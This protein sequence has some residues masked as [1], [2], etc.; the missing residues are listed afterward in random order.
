MRLV[1]L[2]SKELNKYTVDP[3]MLQKSKRPCAL[4]IQLFYKGTRRDFAIPLR[5]NISPNA[6]K[7]Q[8]FPLPPRPTTKDG[9]HHGVHY[10]KMFPVDRTKTNKFHTDDMYYKII[11]AI[12]DKSEKEIIKACQDYLNKYESG[13]RPKYGTD[14]DLLIGVIDNKTNK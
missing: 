14:L 9:Y 13:N 6:P 7:D 12:L 11:K 2:D 10:I 5:S 4:V 3:E 8:Y 1:S